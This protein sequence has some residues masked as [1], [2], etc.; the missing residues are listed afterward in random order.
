[1]RA[2]THAQRHAMSTDGTIGIRV[3]GE[4]RRIFAVEE[5]A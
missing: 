1:M 3:N 2:I 4:H 5:G